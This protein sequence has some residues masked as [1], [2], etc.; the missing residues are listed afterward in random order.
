M[1]PLAA[2]PAPSPVVR[3]AIR[4]E[5]NTLDPLVTTEFDENQIAEAMFSALT[6]LDDR[7]R[8]QPDLA[9][10]VPTRAN[11]GVSADGK[12]LVYRLRPNAR[13]QDGVPVTADDVV[14]TYA[15][16]RDP[17]VPF[18]SRSEYDVIDRVEARDAHTVVVRLKRPDPDFAY[19]LFVN[20]QNGC[21]VPKHLLAH[22]EDIAHAP[23]GGAPVGS[24]P[25][26]VERWERGAILHL[27]ANPSYFGGAP[28]VPRIDLTFVATSTTR[29]VQLR[30]HETDLAVIDPADVGAIAGTAGVGVAEAVAPSLV[31]LEYRVDVSPFDDARVRHALA[32][33]LDRQTIARKTFLGYAVPATDL[34]PPQSPF[35]VAVP[36]PP[37]DPTAAGRLLDAAGWHRGSDGIRI[38][39][40]RR[41]AFAL[42]TVA[43]NAALQRT[44]VGLQAAW[45]ALGVEA[46]LR[47]EPRNLLMAPGGTLQ[48]GAY[49]V[50]LNTFGY[51]LQPDRSLQ[52]A[53]ASLPPNGYNVSRYRNPQLDRLMLQARTMLDSSRRRT[54]YA[55]VAR[56][57]NDDAPIVPIVWQK[58][59]TGVATRLENVRPEPVNSDFWNVTDWRLRGESKLSS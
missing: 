9:L 48:R 17:R 38:R 5:P 19:E 2:I 45:N 43:G 57:E 37:A 51:G 52:L 56:R 16:I 15:K 8:P 23:F 28:H 1:L 59:I 31:M 44:A 27:V 39:G 47:S 20:G 32:A 35:H 33:V 55:E 25:Y 34:L 40:G 21:I 6:L 3:V 26:R 30:T 12:T 7:G 46:S 13:W 36:A 29:A 22:V 49:S 11:G 54:L 10:A 14:F 58:T 42:T 41:L 4:Q 53:I 24:G 50:V 18:P